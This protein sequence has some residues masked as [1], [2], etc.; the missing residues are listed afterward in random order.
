MAS[1]AEVSPHTVAGTA[2]P[3]ACPRCGEP[4]GAIPAVPAASLG[5]LLLRRC[6]RC[7]TRSANGHAVFSCETCGLP[8]V[9][10]SLLPRSDQRCRDCSEGQVPADLPDPALASATEAEVLSALSDLWRFLHSERTSAYLDR[11]ARH[12]ATRMDGAPQVRVRLTE[13][14]RLRTL[15]LPSGTLLVSKGTIAGLEDEAELAFVLGHEI[16]HAASGDA[17]VRLVRLGFHAVA[18]GRER[19][20]RASWGEAV[21]D[22]MR[23]GYGKARERDADARA[24]EAVLALG[25]DAA[26]VLRYLAR[27]HERIG[28]GDA[29]VADLAVSHPPPRSRAQHLER[30]YYGRVHAGAVLQVNRDVFRRAAGAEALAALMLERAGA[31]APGRRLPE[32]RGAAAPASRRWLLWGAAAALAAGALALFLL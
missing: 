27:L 20:P 17:A 22:L 8:F 7:G 28:A 12:V 21:L 3:A 24:F 26:S 15:A 30:A 23:L 18:H 19:A 4:S 14:S 2:A 29:E 32:A 11:I 9:A 25:Y 5:G 6:L 31:F 16:A 1:R 13:D 10:D